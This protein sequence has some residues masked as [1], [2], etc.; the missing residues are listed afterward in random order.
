MST[1]IGLQLKHPVVNRDET[2]LPP[3]EYY[4]KR[5]WLGLYNAPND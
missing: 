3:S 1:W 5:D 4:C 2:V